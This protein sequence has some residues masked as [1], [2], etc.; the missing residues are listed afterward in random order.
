MAGV[1]YNVTPKGPFFRSLYD[2]IEEAQKKPIIQNN[3]FNVKLG[4]CPPKVRGGSSLIELEHEDWMMHCNWLWSISKL[5]TQLLLPHTHTC[6]T[7]THSCTHTNS[8]TWDGCMVESSHCPKLNRFW[9]KS[10]EMEPSLS[11][12]LIQSMLHSSWHTGITLT[13]FEYRLCVY[14]NSMERSVD[15][16]FELQFLVGLVFNILSQKVQLWP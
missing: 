5:T 4:K 15:V 14:C 9:E 6:T 3:A 11:T 12:K 13:I 10:I 1:L 2:L 7:L 8:L 16:P